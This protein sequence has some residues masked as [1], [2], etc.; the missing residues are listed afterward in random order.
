VAGSRVLLALF[1]RHARPGRFHTL[2]ARNLDLGKRL[3]VLFNMI[4][5]DTSFG[6]SS[7][8]RNFTTKA[9]LDR[10][11][12]G[13]GHRYGCALCRTHYDDVNAFRQ[14]LDLAHLGYSCTV[15]ACP[16]WAATEAEVVQHLQGHTEYTAGTQTTRNAFKPRKFGTPEGPD[17][18]R[19]STRKP[20]AHGTRL[21]ADQNAKEYVSPLTY[22][23]VYPKKSIP[24]NRLAGFL[25]KRFPGETFEE[26][27]V[28]TAVVRC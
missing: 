14:H 17:Y 25:H 26:R 24:W 5:P 8:G 15:G 2:R 28:S 21:S 13:S 1:L 27:Q 23:S 10:H 19:Y 20:P 18:L 22:Q 11:M 9:N 12:D 3:T 7:C 16:H 4:P 6:C